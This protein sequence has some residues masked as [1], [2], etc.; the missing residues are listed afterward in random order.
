MELLL[1][2]NT[3]LSNPSRNKILKIMMKIFCNC[4]SKL[5]ILQHTNTSHPRLTDEHRAVPYTRSTAAGRLGQPGVRAALRGSHTDV[6]TCSVGRA[7]LS[8]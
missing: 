6:T 4:S 7:L 3:L 8:V 5:P 2:N 1:Y